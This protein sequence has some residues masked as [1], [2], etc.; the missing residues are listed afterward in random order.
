MRPASRRYR[1]GFL[2]GCVLTLTFL[3]TA[4]ADPS[5]KP[6]GALPPLPADGAG[7]YRLSLDRL[8]GP[9]PLVLY[10]EVR[11][12]KV[13]HVVGLS[14]YDSSV[15]HEVDAGK[16]L[17]K[18][19]RLQGTASVTLWN[20]L[21][22]VKKSDNTF[23]TVEPAPRGKLDVSVDV[24]FVG[25]RGRGTY[26]SKGAVGKTV[27]EL[28]GDV[29][30]HRQPL[31][32]P[33][34]R[35]QCEL[36]LYAA[37]A[38]LTAHPGIT[39]RADFQKGTSTSLV[40]YP[41]P[42][43]S[44]DPVVKS[45]K[46]TMKDGILRGEVEVMARSAPDPKTKETK[47]GP[48]VRLSIEGRALGHL[49]I[50]KVRTT[51][52]D[53]TW[54]TTFLGRLH[55]AL[56]PMPVDIPTRTWS[57]KSDPKADP[58][59]VREAFTESLQPVLPG[60]PGKR[61]FWTWRRVVQHGVSVIHPP[62]F[63]LCQ[64]DGAAQ[65]RFTVAEAKTGGQ[66]RTFTADKPWKPLAPIWKELPPGPYKLRVAALDGTG[67]EL[68]SKMRM[69]IIQKEDAKPGVL[70]LDAISFT[71]RPSF[72]GSWATPTREPLDGALQIARWGREAPRLPSQRHLAHNS[73][74]GGGE[75]SPGLFNAGW[76]WSQL[77]VRALTNDP[78]ERLL[79]E[80][81]LQWWADTYAVAQ[82]QTGRLLEKEGLLY[83][84]KE[85]T[86]V[87]HISGHALI[88]A[89]HETGDP[90]FKEMA[91]KFGESLAALQTPSGTWA[92]LAKSPGKP[93]WGFFTWKHNTEFGAAEMLWVLGRIRCELKTDRF[94]ETEKK[95]YAWV[96]KHGVQEMFWPLSTP[97]SMSTGY[98]INI[99]A[100]PAQCF[101]RYLLEC[102]T[103]KERDLRLAEDLAR[104]TEDIGVRWA[105]LPPD[106]KLA[107]AVGFL[108][109]IPT[110]DRATTSPPVNN[111][112]QAVMYLRL[113]QA[114][115]KVLYRSKAD[116]LAG[117]VLASLD[118]E[119]GYLN[120]S[121]R[122]QFNLRENYYWHGEHAMVSG[123]TAQLLREYVRLR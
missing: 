38:D 73:P 114:T 111:M 40:T 77:H 93:I 56:W 120:S 112:M 95:A 65:Y 48:S 16:L 63:D 23:A 25:E 3:P 35:F 98:P 94:I 34:D 88:D 113:H 49:L 82:R 109:Y 118:P 2:V 1:F 15:W 62:S 36:A 43:F 45:G 30:A 107:E 60:E 51:V 29:Y 42:D 9:G 72:A 79:I 104:W 52:G 5:T 69:T 78:A 68:A 116:A 13:V 31:P 90:R 24:V 27:Q 123:W 86:P 18:D 91:L 84:Y 117:S 71:K 76:L 121:M 102:V 57:W 44:V 64:T 55:D 37:L 21:T 105:P 75:T 6:V 85:Y 41:M 119:T 46:L 70:E 67:K 53:K 99:H 89:W 8:M 58:A 74:G 110:G 103:E 106:G 32:V 26:T 83:S 101:V 19:Q 81:G 115:G 122:P 87:C 39:L 59:L 66:E 7:I 50:G 47:P 97:H 92:S 96:M 80:D 4:P 14:L 33:T 54:T 100:Q 20:S 108:P 10:A 22:R 12:G 28:K 11:G 17:L 61:G